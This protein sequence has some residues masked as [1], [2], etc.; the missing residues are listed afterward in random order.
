MLDELTATLTGKKKE[1]D[2]DAEERATKIDEMRLQGVLEQARAEVE[3]KFPANLTGPN[4]DR[5][6]K[7]ALGEMEK[8][9][10]KLMAEGKEA[11]LDKLLE[12]LRQAAAPPPPRQAPAPS[13]LRAP[14][15]NTGSTDDDYNV[16]N[17]P[18][19]GS[20]LREG[21]PTDDDY[22]VTNLPGEG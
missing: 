13:P 17:L 22:N 5:L 1:L 10:R 11:P 7:K 9:A 14:T 8:Q 15:S 20:P 16:T 12:T 3:K 4:R 2:K 18:G 6:L 21:G 19:E